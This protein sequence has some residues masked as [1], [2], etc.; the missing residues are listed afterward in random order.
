VSHRTVACV[1]SHVCAAMVRD[2]SRA[3]A[4]V[5]IRAVACVCA[6]V[7]VVCVCVC[8]CACVRVCAGVC[9]CRSGAIPHMKCNAS[10]CYATHASK[11][12]ATHAS[13][14]CGPSAGARLQVPV[15]RCASK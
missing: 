15:C 7:L 11:C 9:F 1:I 5:T 6:I 8:L 2:W 12:Y 4:R 10:L 13:L 14:W 3:R